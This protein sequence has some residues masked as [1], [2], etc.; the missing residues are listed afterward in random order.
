MTEDGNY[1]KLYLGDEF[2]FW[3]DN[4]GIHSIK[5]ALERSRQY[6]YWQ[7]RVLHPTSNRS[8]YLAQSKKTAAWMNN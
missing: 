3:R 2:E 7:I 5:E 4:S 8:I 6:D 1:I